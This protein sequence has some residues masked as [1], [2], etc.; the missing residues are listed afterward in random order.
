MR[1]PWQHGGRSGSMPWLTLSCVLSHTPCPT[2]AMP[3]PCRKAEGMAAP[4]TSKERRWT[5]LLKHEALWAAMTQALGSGV[6]LVISILAAR[7]LG[8]DQ[9]GQYVLVLTAVF[10]LSSLQYHL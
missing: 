3:L 7:L 6:S 10:L 8:V 5:L 9:F 4:L 1:E 2:D